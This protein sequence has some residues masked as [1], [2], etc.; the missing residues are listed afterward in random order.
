MS[1]EKKNKKKKLKP[2]EKKKLEHNLI[3]NVVVENNPSA[4][5]QEKLNQ[6]FDFDKIFEEAV[7]NKYDNDFLTQ[8][9]IHEI[10]RQTRISKKKDDKHSDHVDSL[11][12][13]LKD[14]LDW[15]NSRQSVDDPFEDQYYSQ[16]ANDIQNHQNTAEDD[17]DLLTPD[18]PIDDIERDFR[19]Q[20]NFLMEEPASNDEAIETFDRL[21][22]KLNEKKINPDLAPTEQEILNESPY[23]KEYMNII[24]TLQTGLGSFDIS[25]VDDKPKSTNPKFTD[26][27]IE[28]KL[29]P[30]EKKKLK[31]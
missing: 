11:L 19:N 28:K 13:G 22:G 10:D 2:W 29:K 27:K 5:I 8:E 25:T 6:P 12:R 26:S 3:E 17:N 20:L 7:T 23:S 1:E 4:D 16:M 15:E 18:F 21:L 31:K 14:T 24:N 9:E 30:W